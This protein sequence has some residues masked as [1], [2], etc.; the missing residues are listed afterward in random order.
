MSSS[1][2][3]SHSYWHSHWGR[4]E[5]APTPAVHEEPSI[6]SIA[7]YLVGRMERREHVQVDHL[8]SRHLGRDDDRTRT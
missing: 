5:A 8:A 4:R 6:R 2:A 1:S 7:N 3:K